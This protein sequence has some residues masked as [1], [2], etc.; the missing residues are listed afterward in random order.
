M[1]FL[2]GGGGEKWRLNIR[3]KCFW[4]CS[5][6]VEAYLLPEISKSDTGLELEIGHL[7]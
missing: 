5:V 1:K 4:Y 2:K 6:S 7:L 3:K